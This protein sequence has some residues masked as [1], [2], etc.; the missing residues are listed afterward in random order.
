MKGTAEE[1][2]PTLVEEHTQEIKMSLSQD[3]IGI[4]LQRLEN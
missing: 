2:T 4:R 1:V 3:K